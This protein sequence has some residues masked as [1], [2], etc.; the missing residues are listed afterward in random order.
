VDEEIRGNL[1]ALKR[2]L[3][4]AAGLL[5]VHTG[6]LRDAVGAGKLGVHVRTQIGRQ[7]EAV[8]LGH[9]TAE[10]PE[11][12]RMPVRV[13]ALASPIAD[14]VKAVRRPSSVG[15]EKLRVLATDTASEILNRLR[16][17]VCDA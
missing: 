13:F 17:L 14:L 1:E 4:Q 10:L 16:M 11:Y 8:G 9:F 7:L 6:R 3:E 12:Q 5:K 2:D 15:E